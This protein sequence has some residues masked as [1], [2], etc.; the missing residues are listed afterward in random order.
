[1]RITCLFSSLFGDGDGWVCWRYPYYPAISSPWTTPKYEHTHRHASTRGQWLV[2]YK[3]LK[4]VKNIRCREIERGNGFW[5]EV[6][7]ETAT[8]NSSIH[9]I[10]K[11]TNYTHIYTFVAQIIINIY[12][13]IQIHPHHRIQAIVLF[14]SAK[15][16][17]LQTWKFDN[18]KGPCKTKNNV[19]SNW[20]QK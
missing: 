12:E 2:C 7:K 10:I 15:Y 16:F 5:Q 9:P 18:K 8:R 11:Q 4:Y 3:T 17:D 20:V 14:I 1:M 19:C 6:E 13:W